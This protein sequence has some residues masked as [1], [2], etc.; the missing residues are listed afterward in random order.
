MI[1]EITGSDLYGLLKL[2]MQSHDNPMPEQA[3]EFPI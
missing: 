2:Y 1:R 3:S